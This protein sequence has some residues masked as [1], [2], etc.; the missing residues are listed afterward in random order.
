M[1]KATCGNEVPAGLSQEA[2]KGFRS[3][4]LD[5]LL[6]ITLTV[7]ATDAVT[8]AQKIIIPDPWTSVANVHGM[9]LASRS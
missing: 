3:S 5:M 2:L 4:S 8:T 6:S 9:G 1:W 7:L